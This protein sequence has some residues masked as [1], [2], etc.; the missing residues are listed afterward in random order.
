MRV[1]GAIFDKEAEAEEYINWYNE[2]TNN[3][4]NAV[5]NLNLPKVYIESTS[6][7]PKIGELGTYGMGAG[8]TQQIRIANGLNVAKGLE[9]EWPKVDWEWVIKQNPEVIILTKYCPAEKLGWD[10]TPSTDSVGLEKIIAEVQARPGAS[11][12]S[13]IKNNKI[14]VIDA[15]KLFGT[16]GVVGLTYLAKIIHPEVQI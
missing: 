1:M 10:N 3:A 11:S 7:S 13:A 8:V 14:Y 16:D 15:Y 4:K 12:V 6:T 5:K 9:L 2:K